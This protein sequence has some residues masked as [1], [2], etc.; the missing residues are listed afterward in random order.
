MPAYNAAAY[1]APA[2]E[3]ILGQSFGDFEFI[4]I[5]DGSRDGTAAIVEGYR[6]ERIRFFRQPNQGMARTLNRAIELSRGTLLA[7]QD[8]DDIALP[9]RF[10]KQVAYLHAHPEVALVG[11]AAEIWLEEGPSGRFHRHPC[12]CL[13]LAFEMHFDNYLV[14]S[15]VMMRRSAIEAVGA[16]T[17]LESRRHEDFELWSRMSRRFKMANLPEI[18]QVYREHPASM[19]RTEVFESRCIMLASENIAWAT[20]AGAVAPIHMALASLMRGSAP[21]DASSQLAE[22]EL[23]LSQTATCT[24]SR[25]GEPPTAISNALAVRLNSLRHHYYRFHP[26]QRTLRR[27][28]AFLAR[29]AGRLLNPVRV[30][31]G[32]GMGLKRPEC[33]AE[34]RA[35]SE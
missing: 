13:S 3:S 19:C 4:I 22:L 27:C 29:A 14:H 21:L 30:M 2:I 10:E 20:G 15:S 35:D 18:L 32:I 11:T 7:R 8:A 23:L 25:H 12:D 9:H 5:D 33:A 28:R 34:D 26:V 16:Y 1:L 17:T 31:A 24:A 6:D